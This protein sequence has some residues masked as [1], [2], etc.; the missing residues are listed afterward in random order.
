[1]AF[2][3]IRV[4]HEVGRLINNL[5]I[6]GIKETPSEY[7]IT[8]LIFGDNWPISQMIKA[9]ATTYEIVSKI[10]PFSVKANKVSHFPP[11][12]DH[13]IPIIAP[14]KSE[15]LMQLHKK[16]SKAFDG[17]K[18]KFSKTFKEYRP[19]ITLAYSEDGHD[20]FKI[21]PPIE[22]MVNEIVLWGGDEGD[23]R[24]FTTFQLKAPERKKHGTLFNMVDVFEKVA[25]I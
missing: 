14:I 15:E 1:M 17:D 3:G 24:L 19:H 12:P 22:F 9:T 4:P 2:L 8:L 18:I 21:D 16:L 25:S 23:S 11:R 13:P 20:D 7:H 10:E 6:P 5:E